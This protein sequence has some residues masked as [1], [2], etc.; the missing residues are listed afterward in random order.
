MTTR[1]AKSS[2]NNQSRGRSFEQRFLAWLGKL[3]WWAHFMQ[4]ASDGSQPFDIIAIT[5]GRVAAFDCKTVKGDRFPLS[6]AEENQLSAFQALKR[7]GVNTTY[8][9][10]EKEGEECVYMIPSSVVNYYMEQGRKS[11]LLREVSHYATL[12][13]E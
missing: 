6:R 3:G 9:V 12:R 4:P 7:Q 10:L 5:D 2:Q 1:S 8:F 13:I 11:I